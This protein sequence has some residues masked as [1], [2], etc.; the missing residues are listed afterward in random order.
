MFS[1]RPRSYLV[2]LRET[3]NRETPGLAEPAKALAKSGAE[4]IGHLHGGLRLGEICQRT[5]VSRFIPI[6]HV[7]SEVQR[8]S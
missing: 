7:R 3:N 8:V 6:N 1:N 5:L 4:G 2:R